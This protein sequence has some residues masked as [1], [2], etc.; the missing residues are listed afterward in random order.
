MVMLKAQPPVVVYRVLN[1]DGFSIGE[2]RQP[3]AAPVVGRGA[4]TV[5]LVRAA[6]EDSFPMARSS[7]TA[8]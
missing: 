7:A 6:E 3:R 8:A 4:G 2:V 5:L 1:R